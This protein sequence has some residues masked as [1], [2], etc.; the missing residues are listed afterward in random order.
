MRVLSGLFEAS[1]HFDGHRL[2]E[3]FCG[4]PR[5]AG[6]GPDALPG[7]LLAA[8][9]GRRGRVRHAAGLPGPRDRRRQA[10]RSSLRAPRLPA[11]I[12]WMKLRNLS[13]GEHSVD[14]LLQRYENNVGIE[15]M[16]NEGRVA[17]GVTL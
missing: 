14:L 13:V 15:V 8:G 4:F 16:R 1:L 9:L 3:L 12:Q 5:R 10:A 7:G 6:E 2:P 17:V 11:F